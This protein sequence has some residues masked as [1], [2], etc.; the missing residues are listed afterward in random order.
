MDERWKESE[1]ASIV[2]DET[3][4][5]V[6]ESVPCHSDFF[7]YVEWH[8]M[9][10]VTTQDMAIEMMILHYDDYSTDFNATA[11]RILDFLELEPAGNPRPFVIGKEYSKAYYTAEERAAVKQVLELLSLRVTWANIARYF[12]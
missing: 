6:M 3:I 7:R 8:N 10:F 12:P 4:L 1:R 11:K 9:A 5:D 2:Y